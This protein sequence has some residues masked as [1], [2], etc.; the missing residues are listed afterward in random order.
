MTNKRFRIRTKPS[1]PVLLNNVH[2]EKNVGY[3]TLQNLI[4]LAKEWGAPFNECEVE[5]DHGYG[6]GYGC[7]CTAVL[8]WAGPEPIELFQERMDKYEQARAS[9]DVWA[10]ENKDVIVVELEVRKLLKEEAARALAQ[11]KMDALAVELAK[12]QRKLEAMS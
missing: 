12:T 4:D 3:Y 8:S 1:K 9:Y 7:D 2:H 5:I 10:E 6:Y 11:K